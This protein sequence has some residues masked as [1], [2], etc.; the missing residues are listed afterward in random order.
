MAM[1]EQQRTKLTAPVRPHLAPD[2][3]VVEVTMGSLHELRRG[4]DRARARTVVVTDRR[5]VLFRRK[6]GGGYDLRSLDLGR[7]V[8]VDHGLGRITG[9]LRLTSATGEV[10]RITSV[11]AGDVERIAATLQQRLDA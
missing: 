9:E 10:T 11:P 5:I 7:L 3:Q 1:T 2:E 6:L 4:K 8:A